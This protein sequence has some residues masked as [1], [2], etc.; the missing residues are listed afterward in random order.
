MTDGEQFMA[1]GLPVLVA[2]GLWVAKKFIKPSHGFITKLIAIVTVYLAV[3]YC[4]Y[5]YVLPHLVA[6]QRLE[7]MRE[8]T[9]FTFIAYWWGKLFG[10]PEFEVKH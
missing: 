7:F 2:A 4:Y 10:F 1:L 6:P 5:S 8:M 9:G 3:S